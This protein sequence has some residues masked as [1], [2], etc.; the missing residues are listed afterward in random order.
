MVALIIEDFGTKKADVIRELR[1][2]YPTS[3][4][5]VIAA[6]E[7]ARPVLMHPLFS[8]DNPDFAQHLLSFL[9]WLEAH[10]LSYKAFRVL[11]GERFDDANPQKYFMITA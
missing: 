4:L 8:R 6:V 7:G 1:R 11:D 3:I 5:E 9:E 10:S 2:F